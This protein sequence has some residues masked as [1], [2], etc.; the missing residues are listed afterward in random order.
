MFGNEK[1]AIY[2]SWG[3]LESV[4]VTQG[5]RKQHWAASVESDSTV[6]AGLDPVQNQMHWTGSD[7]VKQNKKFIFK[8]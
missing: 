2:Y 6:P 7:P 3:P 1:N 8:F 5:E 4:F